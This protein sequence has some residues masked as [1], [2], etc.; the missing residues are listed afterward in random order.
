M[1]RLLGIVIVVLSMTLYA[2]QSVH[3]E[4]TYFERLPQTFV[5]GI[6]NV[7]TSPL[8]IPYR[9]GEHHN[10]SQRPMFREMAGFVHG[11]FGFATR[12]SSGAWD[13]GMAFLPGFQ[14][15]IPP[16]PETIY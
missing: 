7:L 12:I 11:L 4:E 3:A 16:D 15:G 14:E 2:P 9:V 10:S 6:R 8:E 5:R 1:K 13:M